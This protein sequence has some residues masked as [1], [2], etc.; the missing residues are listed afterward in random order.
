[1]SEKETYKA[2]SLARFVSAPCNRLKN[3]S[4]VVNAI[5]S[6]TRIFLRKRGFEPKV[7]FFAQKL[8]NLGSV[9]NE[10]MQLNRITE[11]AWGA[12]PPTAG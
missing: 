2:G 9:M 1:M 5:R 10:L 12:E 4:A 3:L 8:S 7:N 6:A 11:R